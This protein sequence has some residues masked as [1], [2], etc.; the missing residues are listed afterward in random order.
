[1]RDSDLLPKAF[2]LWLCSTVVS[3]MGVRIN[4]M[5]A[6]ALGY[7][8]EASFPRL[9]AESIRVRAPFRILKWFHRPTGQD[10]RLRTEK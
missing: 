9:I 1:M 6:D 7:T 4:C 8:Q 2:K 10:T 3:P 5:V